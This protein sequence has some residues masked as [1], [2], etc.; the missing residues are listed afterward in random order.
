[1]TIRFINQRSAFKGRHSVEAVLFTRKLNR[2]LLF[3][4]TLFLLIIL[5]SL[6]S[7]L[8]QGAEPLGINAPPPLK[9]LSKNEKTQL[10]SATEVK[11]RTKTALALMEVRLLNAEARSLKLE[12]REMFDELG[13]FH[14]LVDNTLDFLTKKNND[15]GKI[16]NNFKRIE[17]NLRKY[18]TRLELVRRDLPI[19]YE[20]YVRQLIKYIREARTRA[21]EPLFEDSVISD[22]K[23]Q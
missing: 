8:A 7:V 17:L 10:E 4:Q 23:T 14:A 18:I 2:R 3:D 15:S 6:Q 11:L 20:A 19:E 12:Y 5:C 13:G 1:M 22:E 9:I 16:L 21:V